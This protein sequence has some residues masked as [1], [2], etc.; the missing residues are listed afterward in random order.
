MKA[1][2]ADTQVRNTALLTKVWPEDNLGT[3]RRRH[4]RSLLEEYYLA[5]VCEKYGADKSV[6]L[7]IVD[8]LRK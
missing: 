2:Q 8:W 7:L 3:I 4:Q 6:L 5:I 1:T